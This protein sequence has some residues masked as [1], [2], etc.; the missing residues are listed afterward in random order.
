MMEESKKGKIFQDSISQSRR[1]ESSMDGGK[2]EFE[3][4][5]KWRGITETPLYLN[6]GQ[7]R[8]E[9]RKRRV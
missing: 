4:S 9:N 1:F 3:G 6:R 8:G 7:Y 2:E 5:L